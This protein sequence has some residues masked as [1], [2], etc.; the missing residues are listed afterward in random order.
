[1]NCRD[2]IYLCLMFL[3][4]P[5]W[6]GTIWVRLLKLKGLANQLLHAWV[7]GFATILAASQ[8]ILVPLVALEQTF[9]TAIS[10]W[11]AVLQLLALLAFYMMLRD[12]EL[13]TEKLPALAGKRKAQ[14]KE[15]PNGW[16]IAFGLIAGVM[17]LMQAYIPA[18]YEHS[19][20]DDARFIAEQVSAVDHDTMYVD[21]P[22]GADFM[23][24]DQGEVRKDLTSPWAMFMA[25]NAKLSGMEP[26]VL[27]HS[28]A[29][30]FL[31]MLCYGVYVLIGKA[32]FQDDWEKT[33][34]FLIFLSVIHLAGYTS[35]H[36]M[37]S[38]LLLRIWQGKAMC[39]SFMLPL[40]FYLFYQIMRKDCDKRWIP[41][42]YVVSTG[43]CLL[44]GIG[45]VTAPI[46]LCLYGIVDF[47][48]CRS[49]KKT[50][51]IWMA[52][53][54]CAVFLCWYMI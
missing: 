6:I 24:W 37:A 11:K 10:V 3:I 15:K 49:W 33:F 1:M 29:P 48:Y 2:V 16:A 5:V 38:M 46:M 30:F 52:A 51:A 43:A 36:T 44:S 9:T 7:L 54:P 23:Y 25:M 18:R 28:Y 47:W 20:D 50:V 8:V 53:I 40:M 35:T 14:K 41:T 21:S 27:S 22:I 26:A 39:A 32:L 17:I 34:L 13:W 12:E 4:V 19:D 31:I 45:I 42:L